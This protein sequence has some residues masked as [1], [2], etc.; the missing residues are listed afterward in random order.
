MS[1]YPDVIVTTSVM[2]G[3]YDDVVINTDETGIDVPIVGF[4]CGP[5]T[6]GNFDRAERSYADY[7][8]TEA[9]AFKNMDFVVSDSGGVQ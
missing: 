4:A 5:P 7:V 1:L 6:R 9:R 8:N 3:Y 2:D